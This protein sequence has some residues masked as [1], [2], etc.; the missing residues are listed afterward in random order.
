MLK[1]QAIQGLDHVSAGC[2]HLYFDNLYPNMYLP[3]KQEGRRKHKELGYIWRREQGTEIVQNRDN[4][5]SHEANVLHNA[6][7]E[8]LEFQQFLHIKLDTADSDEGN[9]EPPDS[10]FDQGPE[11]TE[12]QSPSGWNLLFIQINATIR[13]INVINFLCAFIRS[14]M[15]AV[16]SR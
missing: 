8:Y 2:I 1:L 11:I 4:F 9:K 10:E 16:S 14:W 6:D 3:Q 5:I 12:L 13:E 7:G 15:M